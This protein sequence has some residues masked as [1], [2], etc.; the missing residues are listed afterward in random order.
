M[1]KQVWYHKRTPTGTDRKTDRSRPACVYGA[2]VQGFPRISLVRIACQELYSSRE[3]LG[4][5]NGRRPAPTGKPTGP[6]RRAFMVQW[7]SHPK[8][9]PIGMIEIRLLELS[10]SRLPATA[11]FLVKRRKGAIVHRQGS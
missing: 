11:C 8:S 10:S 3:R 9:S 7:G 5:I 6:D 4:T 1:E 2:G